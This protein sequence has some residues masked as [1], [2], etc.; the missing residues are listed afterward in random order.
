MT[1]RMGTCGRCRHGPTP[2]AELGLC[3]H[4]LYIHAYTL[5]V[6]LATGTLPPDDDDLQ[7]P[8][9]ADEPAGAEDPQG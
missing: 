2:I 8:G 9:P 6:V 4:C 7:E 3:W 1:V 5:M